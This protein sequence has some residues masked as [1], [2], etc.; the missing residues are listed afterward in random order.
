MI[1][2]S[3]SPETAKSVAAAAREA[4]QNVLD[5]SGEGSLGVV[6]ERVVARAVAKTGPVGTFYKIRLSICGYHSGFPSAAEK[7]AVAAASAKVVAPLYLEV[8]G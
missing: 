5:A 7:A 3:T 4:A 2:D 6:K 8:V 1:S